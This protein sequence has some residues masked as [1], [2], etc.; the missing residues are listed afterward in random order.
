MEQFDVKEFQDLDLTECVE[1]MAEIYLRI[2][3]AAEKLVENSYANAGRLKGDNEKKTD[4]K[5]EF[6]IEIGLVAKYLGMTI[7]KKSLNR[8]EPKSFSRILGIITSQNGKVDVVI[9][10]D[11]SYK[12][13]RYTIANAVGRFLLN[14]T[15]TSLKCN[16]AI[17]LIP[18][19]L[20]EIAADVIALFLLLPMK[21]FKDEFLSYLDSCGD[22]PLDVDA[23][24][25]HLGNKSQ[26]SQFNL[27]IGYQQM[28]QVL[29]YQR[30]LNFSRNDF[31]INKILN[32]PYDKIY[33]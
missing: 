3:D 23:W 13:Q 20:E 10:N 11:V 12:T 22:R 9:D 5:Y 32:D 28:K 33:A 15:G 27:A 26:I 18:Q 31:D 6:P 19:S 21:T 29:C 8:E 2:A 17:P 24:L 7:E 4:C 16:Y 1:G 25:I 14:Q 30:Q